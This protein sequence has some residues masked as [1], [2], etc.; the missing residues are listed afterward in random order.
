MLGDVAE[1]FDGS[2]YNR[3]RRIAVTQLWERLPLARIR[4]GT[5]KDFVT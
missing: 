5:G 2:G 3:W 1:G 4:M